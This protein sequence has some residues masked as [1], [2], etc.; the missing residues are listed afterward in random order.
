M[1]YWKDQFQQLDVR[2]KVFRKNMCMWH[3]KKAKNWF[4]FFMFQRVL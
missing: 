1:L 3:N 2:I 4:H